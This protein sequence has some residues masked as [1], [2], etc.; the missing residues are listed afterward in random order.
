MSLAEGVGFGDENGG[1]CGAVLF[2]E[3]EKRKNDGDG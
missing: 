2:M 3:E 1:R